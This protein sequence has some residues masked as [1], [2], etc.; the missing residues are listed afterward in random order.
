MS[1]RARIGALL[2]ISALGAAGSW[3]G[4]RGDRGAA[5]AAV[6]GG[7]ALLNAAVRDARAVALER[8]DQR[9]QCRDLFAERGADGPRLLRTA[10]YRRAA[11]DEAGG[12]CEKGA[13]AFTGMPSGWTALCAESFLKVG[14]HRGAV[15]L[16]HEALHVAGLGEHP[17]HPGALT[18]QEIDRMVGRSC[19]L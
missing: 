14:R 19:G 11:P 3:A 13:V 8:I 6:D 16:I 4:D 12:L 17:H 2:V 15:V 7:G 5:P 18:P 10:T 9:S 1:G